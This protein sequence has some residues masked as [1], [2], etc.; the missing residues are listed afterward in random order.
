MPIKGIETSIEYVSV[1]RKFFPP[2]THTL[3]HNFS[4]LLLNGFTLLLIFPE[5]FLAI[6]SFSY[7]FGTDFKAKMPHNFWT[8]IVNFDHSVY[9]MAK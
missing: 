5:F 6:L 2:N 7:V 9:S 8:R 3:E 4:A 1:F